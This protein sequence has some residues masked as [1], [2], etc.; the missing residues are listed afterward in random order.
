M[1]DI[2][3]PPPQPSFPQPAPP[4]GSGSGPTPGPVPYQAPTSGVP[5]GPAPFGG[6]SA[7]P[8]PYGGP[9]YQ[10][11]ATPT[12]S[13]KA[14]ASLVLGI[15]GVVL[16]FLVIPSVL[17]LIFGIIAIRATGRSGGHLTGKGMAIAGTVLGAVGLVIGGVLIAL[18]VTEVAGTTNV[19]DLEAGQ[20]VE[21]PESGE[22]VARVE[23]F[24]CTEPH[25]AEVIAIEDIGQGDDEYPGDD[26]VGERAFT[27][28]TEAF[29]RYVGL[30]YFKSELEIFQITPLESNWGDD[31]T[32][33]CLAYDP[34]GDLTE[35]IEDA[36]R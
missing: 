21:L 29:E 26:E 1:S 33:I 14:I 32:V 4:P 13:G 12:R 10:P 35:S 25:G 22:E 27:A 23:T 3:P 28:C 7:G 8:P 15:A 31:Q 2:P 11:T 24:E 30:S 19:N 34:A 17:A 36:N 9:A 5:S 6:P 18:V 20:C 16:C